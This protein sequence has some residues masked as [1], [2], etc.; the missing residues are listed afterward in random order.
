MFESILHKE[1]V[2]FSIQRIRHS[3]TSKTL[4]WYIGSI[5]IFR[6][7][8]MGRHSKLFSQLKHLSWTVLKHFWNV[9]MM[10]LVANMRYFISVALFR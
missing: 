10:A 1:E 8:E 6:W 3:T 5:W 7:V 4:C 2:H 9:W